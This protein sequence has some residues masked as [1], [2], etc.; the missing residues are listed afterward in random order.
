MLP[1]VAS[2]GNTQATSLEIVQPSPALDTIVEEDENT[3]HNSCRANSDYEPEMPE[4]ACPHTVDSRDLNSLQFDDPGKTTPAPRHYIGAL[5]V[6]VKFEIMHL[7]KGAGM[8]T[9]WLDA[10]QCMDWKN[11]QAALLDK[12][13]LPRSQHPRAKLGFSYSDFRS[14]CNVDSDRI[15][16]EALDDIGTHAQLRDRGKGGKVRKGKQPICFRVM[17]AVIQL[18]KSCPYSN[19]QL[20][21]MNFL[22]LVMERILVASVKEVPN[23]IAENTSN[24]PVI[25]MLCLM[26]T[27]SFYLMT[28]HPPVRTT[29][30]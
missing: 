7:K 19:L 1:E 11:V 8:S 5:G 2:N 14:P 3:I 24:H 9:L 27:S 13:D 15:W 12:I 21:R 16:I 10:E 25:T 17:N 6:A 22:Q 23:V 20:A 28:P 18:L 26:A 30:A 29:K 4:N